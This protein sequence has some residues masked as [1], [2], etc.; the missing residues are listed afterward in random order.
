VTDNRLVHLL[1]LVRKNYF[2]R[3]SILGSGT[4]WVGKRWEEARWNIFS[5]A[6]FLPPW[7]QEMNE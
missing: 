1:F 6:E 3:G 7:V 5:R 4:T 2:G